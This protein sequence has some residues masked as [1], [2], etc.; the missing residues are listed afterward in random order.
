MGDIG[1]GMDIKKVAV[2]LADGFEETECVA[3][4]DILKR[5]GIEVAGISISNKTE[6]TGSHGIRL[7]ADETVDNVDMSTFDS[8]F[9]PGGMPG[10]LNLTN[11]AR[12][13]KTLR[14]FNEKSK[15]I[16]AICA[17][18]TVLAVANVDSGKTITSYPGFEKKFI[19]S[20][21]STERV[22]VS[23]NLITSRGV[24]T[25]LE[26]AL[27]YVELLTSKEKSEEIAKAILVR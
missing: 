25:V 1:R 20:R 19:N 10:A 14:D 11:S 2:F 3:V 9:L 18:P 4:W 27:K 16:A 22:V 23:D 13:I 21:Y 15:I 5:A 26:F 12:V 6:I 24:G 7:L 17:A 8:V